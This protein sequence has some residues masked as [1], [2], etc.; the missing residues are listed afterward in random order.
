ML[1]ILYTILLIVFDFLIAQFGRFSFTHS[2]IEHVVILPKESRR[3]FCWLCPFTLYLDLKPFLGQMQSISQILPEQYGTDSGVLPKTVV[4]RLDERTVGNSSS[5]FG[6][7][8]GN[9]IASGYIE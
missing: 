3:E 8:S 2:F 4:K 9:N 5:R 7:G 6:P 1:I